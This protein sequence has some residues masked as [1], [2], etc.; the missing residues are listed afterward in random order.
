MGRAVGSNGAM[1]MEA[2]L[3]HFVHAKA[4]FQLCGE[5][6][7]QMQSW[8]EDVCGYKRWGWSEDWVSVCLQPKKPRKPKK[9]KK[10]KMAKKPKNIRSPKT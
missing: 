10:P 3:P 2:T 8:R 4:C 1:Q 6:F 5:H 9:A 7:C